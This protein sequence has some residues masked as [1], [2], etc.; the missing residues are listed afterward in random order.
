MAE[1]TF[2]ELWDKLVI[3][4]TGQERQQTKNLILAELAKL[5]KDLQKEGTFPLGQGRYRPN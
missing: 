2:G 5:K 1:R 3:I 4:A